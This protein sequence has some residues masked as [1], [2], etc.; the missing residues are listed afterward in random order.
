MPLTSTTI[1]NAKSEA[2]PRKLFDERGL[3]LLVKPNGGKL[4]RFK[5]R[6]D[7][8]E[9]LLSLGVYPDVSLKD[10]RDRR[11]EARK[12]VPMAL[13][14]A[15]TAKLKSWQGVAATVLKSWHGNGTPNTP[16]TGLPI[17]GAASFA[18]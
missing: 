15:Q 13:T 16:Q 8:K 3:F 12:L 11:D 14:L 4:W 17:T 2:K 7:G 10:A 1:K 6:F 5:Y 9:K 18:V